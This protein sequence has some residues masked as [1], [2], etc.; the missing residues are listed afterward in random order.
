MKSEILLIS[1]VS[2]KPFFEN[3]I[4]NKNFS[5]IEQLDF[6][7]FKFIN[8]KFDFIFI[9]YEL[10]L[11]DNFYSSKIIKFIKIWIDKINYK[12]NSSQIIL[13]NFIEQNHIYNNFF[14]D[15]EN[16]NSH[17]IKTKK[18]NS[19]IININKKD[20]K[21][22]IFDLNTLA[23][24]FGLKKIYEKKYWYIAKI[25][26]VE[27]FI[28]NIFNKIIEI[29]NIINE[30]EKKII[31]VDLD[32]TLWQGV[33][34]EQGI[35][36]ISIDKNYPAILFYEFQVFLKKKIKEGYL[37]AINSK[38]NLDIVKNAFKEINMPLKLNDFI[39]VKCNWKEKYINMIDISKQTNI[40]LSGFIFIDDSPIERKKIKKF[41]PE[42]HIINYFKDISKLNNKIKNDLIFK[43]LFIT[44]EDTI[45]FKSIRNNTKRNKIA[46]NLSPNQIYKELKIKLILKKDNKNHSKRIIQ[47][48]ERTNQFNFS[49][50][51]YSMQDIEKENIS[52]NVY[53]LKDVFGDYGIIAVIS[54][55]IKNKIL[56]IENF[57]ISCRA[58]GRNIESKIINNLTKN[59]DKKI[60]IIQIKFIENLKN[61]PAKIFLKENDFIKKGSFYEK[62]I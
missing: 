29:K 46:K 13:S 17:L 9:H 30:K 48:F 38:N 20:N 27:K 10:R 59:M 36:G 51:K 15:L 34:G 33:L 60:K 40:S 26:Y 53:E 19:E 5:S 6:Y 42:V 31:V 45:R 41:L 32:N 62:K 47:L 49:Q 1:N 58:L 2:I 28:I 56:F 44:N 43:K 52:F 23:A 55:K 11:E 7:N 21:I 50:K 35:N 25:P 18:L 37:L 61:K 22:I 4:I 54:Y 3:N 8:K 16:N 14:I 57:V 12:N 39:S 24:E